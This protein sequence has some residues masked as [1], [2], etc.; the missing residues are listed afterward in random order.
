MIYI[1]PLGFFFAN[2]FKIRLKKVLPDKF[3]N[4]IMSLIPISLNET[5]MTTS[6]KVKLQ[7]SYRQTNID[8]CSTVIEHKI[9]QIIISKSEQ[10]FDINMWVNALKYRLFDFDI[11]TDA[12]LITWS[13]IVIK[14]FFEIHVKMTIIL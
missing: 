8:K 4:H 11:Y 6:I 2:I 1:K 10:N 12:S 7:K 3:D 13:P 5:R 14:V 9:L